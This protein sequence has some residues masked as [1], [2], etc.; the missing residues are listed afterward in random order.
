MTWEL[1]VEN[2]AGIRA[3]E[4]SIEPGVNAVRA[5][6]WQGK[7]SFLQGIET[8]LGTETP[9]TEGRADG[10]VELVTDEGTFE[11]RLEREDGGVS[12]R[13]TPFLAS[14]YDRLC[15]DLFACLD[16]TNDVRKAVRDGEPLEPL[17]TKPLDFE[18][19]DSQIA[20]LQSERDRVERELERADDAAE[21]RPKL[22]AR[23]T[24]LEDE[25]A[26]LRA[27]R[28][29]LDATSDDAE[30]RDRLSD[31]RA[32]RERVQ[33]RVDRLDETV[34]RIEDRL[35]ETRS[36]LADLSVPDDED[37]EAEIAQVRERLQSLE[38]DRELL[39]G[40]FEANS[41]VLESDRTELLTEVSRDMLGD[42]VDCWL[43]GAETTPEEMA[44]RLDALDGRITEL[45]EEE[46]AY[47]TRVEELEER[48]E[49]VRTARRRERD[50]TDRIGELEASL[51]E[52]TDDRSAARER[53]EELAQRIDEVEASVETTQDRVTDI[54][55]DIKYT[56]AELEDARDELSTA[57]SRA[58]Q[59][60]TL[61][62]DY[63]DL[64]EEITALRNRKDEVKRAL[65]EAFSTAL[66]ELFERFD[67]GFE[68]ARLTSTFEL[69]VARDGR[70]TTLDALS[71]G[72]RELLGF[73]VALAGHE[74]YDVDERV[75][76][77]LLDGLGGLASDNI[78]RFVEYTADRVEY[79]VLTA[80]PEHDGF[81]A[82]E[83]SPA[84]WDVVSHRAETGA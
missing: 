10:R 44:D 46:S 61:A 55:S 84:E 22:Q 40:V 14:A 24:E 7:S 60:E 39:Q 33:R 70:E 77:L 34:D 35:A 23:V 1:T 32:E 11:V 80:Y 9:L 25:L 66:S 36:E 27:D 29:A 38:R 64:T 19:I 13:G 43:C 71:E 82:N 5:S 51:S 6:N 30:T 49:A 81:D 68:M 45:R 3:A 67:T 21:R 52:K 8:A 53:L 37:I 31:L 4:E 20:D 28:D 56:E 59:R 63:D 65:R 58:T 42:T 72:E 15:A 78:A 74:A 18:D 16:E 76:V 83:L 57:E 69:V 79:L 47:R 54:E 41:R 48:R 75:P 17:L 73:V 62:A 50:L 2:V 12:Q 26:K